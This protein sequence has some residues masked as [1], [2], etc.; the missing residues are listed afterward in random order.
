MSSQHTPGPYK[1]N[2]RGDEVMV[3]TGS[4]VGLTLAKVTQ[5]V[6]AHRSQSKANAILFAAAPELLEALQAVQELL[7]DWPTMRA[8]SALGAEKATANKLAAREIITAAIAKAT[9]AA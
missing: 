1:V 4:S 2:H 8:L 6:P 7:A 9:G 5:F 3:A